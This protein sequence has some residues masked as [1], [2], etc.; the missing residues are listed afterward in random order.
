MTEQQRTVG[1]K[2]K[3]FFSDFNLTIKSHISASKFLLNNDT[4]WEWLFAPA[5]FGIIYFCLTYAF[6]VI[7][8]LESFR[9]FEDL[10][11]VMRTYS[12]YWDV[13]ISIMLPMLTTSAVLYSLKTSLLVIIGF[14]LG[15]LGY[16][17]ENLMKKTNNQN[18][19]NE[20]RLNF[21]CC[22]LCG[23]VF[24]NFPMEFGVTLIYAVALQLIAWVP[25]STFFGYFI[26]ILMHFYFCAW[27]FVDIFI[28]RKKVS[29]NEMIEFES[30][31]RGIYFGIGF[32][33]MILLLIPIIGWCLA[34]AITTIAS[35]QIFYEMKEKGEL[36]WSEN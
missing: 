4:L 21:K 8:F 34:P 11:E 9:I 18:E 30:N 12:Y 29:D 27:P 22:S 16:K 7:F 10:L 24:R 36:N 35:Q 19:E 15:R 13:T 6:V 5:V 32:C 31:H 23:S 17:A 33:F 26:F 25:Y 20:I 2:L 14:P 28:T 3:T 1:F